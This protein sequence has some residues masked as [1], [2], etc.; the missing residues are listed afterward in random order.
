MKNKNNRKL[1]LACGTLAALMILF[2]GVYSVTRPGTAAGEK[3]ITV[4]VVHKDG[5][6]GTFTYQTDLEYLGDLLL[7][8]GLIQGEEGPYGLYITTVD[9][10]DA[11]Y[12]EDQS[13]WAFYQDGEYAAQGIDQTPIADGDRFSMVYTIG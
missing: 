10:E 8:E 1:I 5:A 12:E 3:S 6:A 13:Y 4:E 2:L 9:G 7:S 11:I